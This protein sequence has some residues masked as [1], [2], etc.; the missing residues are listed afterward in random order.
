MPTRLAACNP[1]RHSKLSC[2]HARPTCSRC[3]DRNRAASCVYR[4]K[5]FKKRAKIKT[6]A[7]SFDHS[8]QTCGD[9]VGTGSCLT[10][11]SK[12]RTYPNPGYLG[13]SSHTTFFN[14]LP[15]DTPSVIEPLADL[16]DDESIS[17]GAQLVE[18]MHRSFSIPS[19][20]Q[21]V[22]TWIARGVNLALAG[23]FTERC[24]VAAQTI[25]DEIIHGSSNVEDASKSL[26]AASC[27]PLHVDINA[28]VLDFGAHF[29]Q[30]EPR[31]ET[32][33]LFFTAISRATVD[34]SWFEPLYGSEQQRRS[35]R[36]LAM[37]LSD[38]CLDIALSLD[39]LNDLQLM[40]QYENYICHTFVDG[41]QSTLAS[42]SSPLLLIV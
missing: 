11:P 30:H 38:R 25:F 35:L 37:R 41:D 6:G 3:R 42:H 32:L 20:L 14:Q 26:F 21:L 4:A 13:P 16:V 8:R 1:C 18:Q 39:C 36:K 15:S 40:L 17:L 34:M 29:S 28:T 27:R 7:V 33:G 22:R 23:I 12:L 2:D 31:W 19:C 9:D 5:P 10:V 24:A